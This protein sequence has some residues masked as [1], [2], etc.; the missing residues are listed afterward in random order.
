MQRIDLENYTTAAWVVDADHNSE[1]LY[2][3]LTAVGWH[4]N[5]QISGYNIY[6][7]D[8]MS[9]YSQQAASVI[10]PLGSVPYSQ[11]LGDAAVDRLR[12]EYQLGSPTPARYV[13]VRPYCRT[14]EEGWASDWVD[15][16]P[17]A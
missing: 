1:V 10:A 6:A 14:G 4:F 8:N 3:D 16:Q 13:W 12:L 9:D 7:S 5:Q 17:S 11:A 15:T 2:G